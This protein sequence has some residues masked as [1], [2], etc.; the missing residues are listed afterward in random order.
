MFSRRYVS[1]FQQSTKNGDNAHANSK[2]GYISKGLNC[3]CAGRPFIFQF[4]SRIIRIFYPARIHHKL[5]NVRPAYF[6]YQ[7][8]AHRNELSCLRTGACADL[9]YWVPTSPSCHHWENPKDYQLIKQSKNKSRNPVLPSTN[10]ISH[11]TPLERSS[12]TARTHIGY[13]YAIKDNCTI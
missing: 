10:K 11:W 6:F 5:K 9:E 3:P 1:V 7:L 2:L 12:R 13:I 8:H 4:W